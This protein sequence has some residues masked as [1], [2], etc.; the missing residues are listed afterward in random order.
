M[1]SNDEVS[2]FVVNRGVTEIFLVSAKDA[3]DAEDAVNA[4]KAVLIQRRTSSNAMPK[5]EASTPGPQH[6]STPPSG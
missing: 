3:K 4:G 2:E 6:P 1:E 5:P